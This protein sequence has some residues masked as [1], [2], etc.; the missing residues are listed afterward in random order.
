MTLI[1]SQPFLVLA[2]DTA[3]K[4][5]KS[6]SPFFFFSFFLLLFLLLLF[7]FFYYYFL[8]RNS[9]QQNER[10]CERPMT[11]CMLARDV[12]KNEWIYRTLIADSP[13]DSP[14]AEH[15]IQG[16]GLHRHEPLKRLDFLW[17]IFFLLFSSTFSPCLLLNP[18]TAMMLF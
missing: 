17:V 13:V 16:I 9:Y 4:H 5:P 3:I 6:L 18:F 14:E 8:N 15:Q 11:E 7:K 2:C 10:I 12:I 1:T